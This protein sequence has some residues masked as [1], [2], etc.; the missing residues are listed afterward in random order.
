MRHF[1]P[2]LLLVLLVPCTLAV[3]APT[4]RAEDDAEPAK[5]KIVVGT[6]DAPPFSMRDAGGRWHGI[7]IELVNRIAEK[8][9]LE[10]EW[11]ELTLDG[12]LDGV[13][14]GT[15]D[16]AAAAL[17]V[18]AEREERIDFTH[19]FHTSGLGIAVPARPESGWSAILGRV[20]SSE[21]LKAVFALVVLLLAVGFA[22]WLFE[23]KRN[24][25]QFGGKTAAGLGHAFWWSA[26][27]MTTVGYGDKAPVTWAGRLVALIWMFASI[28]LI[29]GFT[30]SI[31]SALTVSRLEGSIHGP[32]DLPGLQ[33]GTVPDSTSE[34]YL[35]ARGI[36]RRRF[37]NVQAA[38][39]AL[40]DGQVEAVVYDAPLLVYRVAQDAR[41]SARL[42][43]LP[44][45]FERQDYAIALPPGAEDRERLNRTLLE[46]INADDWPDV[47]D[48]HLGR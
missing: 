27:T 15:L 14:D 40:A 26:V 12:L 33:V 24:A 39:E 37:P 6:K 18:T 11:R 19:A 35:T 46:I 7:S 9:D 1:L 8:L 2:F 10:V 47:L 34:R 36:Q 38:L 16:A 3:R 43:V 28:I 4:A 25:E 29:A 42:V 44:Q 32:E 13:Q 22:L 48:R 17:T 31:A 20:F 21:F 41:L 5:K 23:R 30:G 45:T